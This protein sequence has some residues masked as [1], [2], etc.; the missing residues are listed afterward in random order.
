MVAKKRHV[1]PAA[2][3][4]DEKRAKIDVHNKVEEILQSKKNANAIFDIFEAL[5]VKLI[6]Q[7]FVS[8]VGLSGS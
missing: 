8:N 4:Q 5:Q 2:A 1:S 3:E 7:S 6:C